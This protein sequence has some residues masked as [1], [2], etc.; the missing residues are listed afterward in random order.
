MRA[1][2]AMSGNGDGMTVNTTVTL[3]ETELIV[4]GD[5]FDQHPDMA[6]ETMEADGAI[7]L[8]IAWDDQ[9]RFI[10]DWREMEKAVKA[11]LKAE[12]LRGNST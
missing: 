12:E 11:L 8:V 7:G 9:T 6:I 10:M 1:V 2:L 3:D 4:E 5:R